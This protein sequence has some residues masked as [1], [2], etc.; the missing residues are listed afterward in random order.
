MRIRHLGCIAAMATCFASTTVVAKCQ[1]QQLGSLPVDMEG[2]RPIVSAKIDGAKARFLLDSGSFYS[3]IGRDAAEQ[4]RLPLT[5]MANDT[6][7]VTGVGG[8]ESAKVATV[9]DF[10]FLG[11]QLHKIPFFVFDQAVGDDVAG[12]IGQNVLRVSD[13]EYDLSDGT[14]RFFSPEG[15][16]SQP[17]AYWAVK[18]PYSLIKLQPMDY[19]ESH[20][21]A[22]AMINGHAVTVWFDTGSPRSMLSLAA[23]ERVGITPTSPGVKSLGITSGIGGAPVKMWVA[24]VETFQ[25]GGEKVEHTHLLIGD[26]APRDPDG[27]VSRAFPD[28][29]LGADFF[30]SHRIYVAYGQSTLYF[31]Y[32]GGPLFNLNLPQFAA[33]AGTGAQ[34]AADTPTDAAG[35]RRRGMA[36]ASMREFDRALADLTRACALA[37]HDAQNPY[38]RGVIYAKDGRFKSALQDFDAAIAMQ[39]DDIDAHFARAELLQSQLDA[40]PTSAA[41]QIRSDLDAVS[42]LAP[43]EAALRLTLSDQYE[44]LGDYS[45]ALGQID[46]WLDNHRLRDERAIG[47]NAR[48]RLRATAN[49]DLQAALD[50]CNRA[51]GTRPIGSQDTGTLITDRQAPA[52]PGILDSRGLV[53]L[54]LG[55]LKDA[56]RDYDTALGVAPNVPTSLYARGL[57]ELREGQKTQGQADLA[58]AEKLDADIARLFANMGLA[59]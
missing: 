26:F 28:L 24:P 30:L 58:A 53:Y 34:P 52:D 11:M 14:V 7:Y 2:L 57:A 35:F 23:A 19:Q 3:S 9:K 40:D 39:P 20:L 22:T 47:L 49:R 29:F 6:V 48:C 17:L 43:P 10:E 31:T 16:Q 15:C 59:P 54:R 25:L 21:R 4:Y 13:V 55:N 36:Y 37:P 45:A 56:I 51:L 33:A 18:T 50:D 1:L 12:L 42:R 5:S 38:Q 46:Q 27:M 8:S 41:T 32:N 44:K